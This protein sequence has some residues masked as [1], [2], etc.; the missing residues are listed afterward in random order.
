[1]HG[2]VSSKEFN[3]FVS[4]DMVGPYESHLFRD[5]NSEKFYLLVFN[6][7]FSRY[8]E[9]YPLRDIK[10]S[11]VWKAFEKWRRKY[12]NPRKL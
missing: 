8:A 5:D 6:D 10:S 11:T 2:S 1:M 7:I 4:V 12:G 3:D 9:F